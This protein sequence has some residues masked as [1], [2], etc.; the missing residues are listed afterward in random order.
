MGPFLSVIGDRFL[1]TA[2]ISLMKTGLVGRHLATAG[3]VQ[4]SPLAFPA[5]RDGQERRCKQREIMGS[6]KVCELLIYSRYWHL[7]GLLY[8]GSVLRQCVFRFVGKGQV[9][10]CFSEMV[11]HQTQ[12][13]SHRRRL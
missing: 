1:D 13:G 5:C 2:R 7:T 8:I 9:A 10:D 3:W 12:V 4:K 11:I 6:L